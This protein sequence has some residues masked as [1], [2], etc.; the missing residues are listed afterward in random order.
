[1][2]SRSSLWSKGYLDLWKYFFTVLSVLSFLENT[3][4]V[5]PNEVITEKIPLEPVNGVGIFKI[6]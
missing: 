6:K 3:A 5:G 1:M 2:M 4:D